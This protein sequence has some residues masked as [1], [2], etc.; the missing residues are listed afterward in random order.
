VLSVKCKKQ[1]ESAW[2]GL[3]FYTF[4]GFILTAVAS[5]AIICA[6]LSLK[7]EI[8]SI[9]SY[10]DYQGPGTTTAKETIET[11]RDSLNRIKPFKVNFAQQ[12]YTDEQL[13]IEE[14]GEIIFKNHQLL[15][16][17][18]LDPDYK[19]FLLEGDN[20]QFYDEDNEQLIIGKI[21]DKS[22]Q[23]VWQMLFSADIF[24]DYVVTWDKARK[25]LHIKNNPGSRT[26]DTGDITI[27]IEIIINDDS[28]PITLIQ[29]DPSGAR[30]VY[31]FK[32]YQSL[33]KIPDN[34]FRLNV[35]KD[36]E[37]IRE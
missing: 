20:Y 23:W 14:S 26:G 19:V 33:K 34:T 5:L 28:L 18:Y 2:R 32:E 9:S 21:K 3:F 1:G 6:P 25:T 4:S 30:I 29:D 37:I 24:R 16:W 17:T 8:H 10:L 27:D 35:P 7:G 36:V 31:H 15:K 11:V 12:V 13:D 22:H